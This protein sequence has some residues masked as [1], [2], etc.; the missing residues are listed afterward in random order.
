MSEAV[1]YGGLDFTRTEIR[2][3][4]Y[5][6]IV[7]SRY[8]PVALFEDLGDPADWE[9]IAAI[10][11]LTNPRLSES[12][13]A[14]DRVPPEHRVNGPGAS[15]LMAPFVHASPDRP[16]RFHDGTHGAL[17]VAKTFRTALREVAQHHAHFLQATDEPPGWTGAFRG[18]QGRLRARLVD[19]RFVPE[20][21]TEDWT[22]SQRIGLE[23]RRAG[24]AGVV[25]A[26]L[27]DPGG[28]A[29]AL[30]R[31]NVADAPVQIDHL[32]YHWDGIRID[33]VR[34]A[35]AQPSHGVGAGLG[36]VLRL[37]DL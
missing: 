14:L 7:P 30:F 28:E 3:R 23:A 20:L 21:R 4:A 2:W 19:A 15:Y 5:H 17:Y 16:G 25:Y 27:R 11:S 37:A 10:E 32:R 1:R 33:I 18:L 35:P 29:A 26:S 34:R 13:G 31:P 6:R 8:P 36:E 12:I 9:T 22:R 24:E